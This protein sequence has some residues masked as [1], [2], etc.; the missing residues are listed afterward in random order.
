MLQLKLDPILSKRIDLLR[1]PL[2]V[3]ILFLHANTT[4]VNLADGAIGVQQTGLVASFIRSYI[5]DVLVRISVPLFY[6]LSGFLFY[7]GFV[8]SKNAYLTK[9]KSRAQSLLVPFLFWNL[10]VL[11]LYAVAQ[12]MPFTAPY[13]S[14]NQKP[15]ASFGAFD[16]LN[17]LFGFTRM[18]I[19]YQFW[20][21]RDLMA[22]VLLVPIIDILLKRI[23]YIFLFF[24]FTAWL[25]E[26][27]PLYIPTSD[28]VFFFYA[29]A[30]LA[31]KEFDVC[32]LD[33]RGNY[34]VALY[35][36][37]SIAD[38]LSPDII[39]HKLGILFGV[40]TVV[41]GTRLVRKN[42]RGVALL[43][44][45]SPAS[46]FVFAAHDPLMT[47]IRKLVYR[48]F[49]PSGDLGSV[50][51]YFATPFVVIILCVATW[52]ILVRILPVPT[53]IITGGR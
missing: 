50:V 30:L 5:S 35:L 18:P 53:R 26:I 49:P 12:A 38:V 1:F 47:V 45:L 37:M 46:F 20:F 6:L 22:L 19:A 7:Y 4:T 42:K 23:P 14:G 13:F 21:I 8:F 39:V 16:Y 17:A 2:I 3:G 31:V 15:V 44:A 34:I 51:L 40:A 41:Y 43:L 25:F 36:A 9:L 32:S 10:L 11:T 33:R 52:S 48:L 27:W 24:T 28:A 29:G